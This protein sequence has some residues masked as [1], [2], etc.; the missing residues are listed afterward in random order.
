VFGADLIC[1]LTV[2]GVVVV[3]YGSALLGRN[4]LRDQSL[5][6]SAAGFEC[7]DGLVVSDQIV[8]LPGRWPVAA[9]GIRDEQC[10]RGAVIE[11]GHPLQGR[12]RRWGQPCSC[13][14]ATYPGRLTR[15]TDA[16][17]T[18]HLGRQ[19]VDQIYPMLT[20]QALQSKTYLRI[21]T[22]S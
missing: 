22:Y 5:S 7:Y 19:V 20:T 1:I 18:Q 12:H 10:D 11:E 6:L 14:S 2:E 3:R 16:F 21:L 8:L 17:I 4:C 15:Q 13:Y 9:D